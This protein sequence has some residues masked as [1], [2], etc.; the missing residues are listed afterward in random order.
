M[1]CSPVVAATLALVAAGA[2][3]WERRRAPLQRADEAYLWYGTRLVRRGAVPLRDFRS[4]EP[5]RYWW[6]A[7]VLALVGDG[8][9]RLRLAVH[10]FWAPALA[11]VAIVT[12]NEQRAWF[13]VVAVVALLVVWAEPQFKLFEPA[14]MLAGVVAGSVMLGSASATAAL[15]AGIVAGSASLV[16]VN[17]CLYLGASLGL[18]ALAGPAGAAGVVAFAA[19][20]ALGV[21]PLALWAVLARGAAASLWER[22]VRAVLSRGSTNLPLPVPWPWRADLGELQRWWAPAAGVVRWSFALLPALLVPGAVVVLAD[23]DLRV[24][25]PLLAAA[26]VVGLVGLH[27]A[28]SRADATHLAQAIGPPA[29]A[30]V[31]ALDLAPV[32]VAVGG[33]LALI[34]ASVTAVASWRRLEPHEVVWVPAA[35]GR[36]TIP[37]EPDDAAVVDAARVHLAG[38]D[39]GASVLAVPTVIGVLVAL[40]RPSAVY[41]V[42]AVYPAPA[43]EDERMLDELASRRPPLAVVDRRAIDGRDDLQFPA[44]HPRTWAWLESHYSSVAAPGA[45]SGVDVLVP[46]A[47]GA[48]TDAPMS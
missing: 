1:P 44:T 35:D 11:A 25:H 3:W 33:Q 10:A 37:M 43:E 12:S 45:P 6:C 2:R 18:L 23:R 46:R 39:A 17:L 19:G 40:D 29:V 21:A 26:V 9:A 30:A 24:D 32:A 5:G 8:A 36:T 38:A 22:R 31:M 16:G 41:D 15:G 47:G 48:G 7:G 4:Y 20:A 28:F 34:A 42:F 27:H 13:T 14:T